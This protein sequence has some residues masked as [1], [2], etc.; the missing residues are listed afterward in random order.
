MN[1]QVATKWSELTDWQLEELAYLL[2][3][4]T[5]SD[6][7]LTVV[8]I[9][10]KKTNSIGE[11]MRFARL[12]NEAPL[13]ELIKYTEFLG[14]MPDLCHFPNLKEYSVVAPGDRL[15]NITMKHFSVVDAIFYKW[16]DTED[17][18]YLRQLVAALYVIDSFDVL[19]LPEVAEKTDAVPIK[20]MYVIGLT[21]LAIRNAI[22]ERFP[23]VFPKVKP[24]SEDAPVFRKNTY[25]PFS[26]VITAMAMDEVQPLG[27]LKECKETNIYDF[28]E[29][30]S[31]SILRA[32]KINKSMK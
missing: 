11:Q 23:V 6:R 3:T 15:N 17:E 19:K 26:K 8:S 28:L 10:F 5:I 2:L 9:L 7:M 14:Q 18:L 16:R 30:L 22:T 12:L 24:Q 32:E 1:Y 27:T 20:K 21:Y 13:S 25:T 29:T 31:E 4:E